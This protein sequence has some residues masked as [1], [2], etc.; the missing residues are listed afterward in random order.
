MAFHQQLHRKLMMQKPYKPHP[1]DV[2]CLQEWEGHDRFEDKGSDN[3]ILPA[4]K[5]NQ[6]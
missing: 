4:E 6:M 3:E 5:E 2:F 1:K